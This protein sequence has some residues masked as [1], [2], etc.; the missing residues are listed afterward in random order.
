MTR[1]A[2]NFAITCWCRNYST[3][4]HVS[5]ECE[6]HRDLRFSVAPEASRK[7]RLGPDRIIGLTGGSPLGRKVCIPV[8]RVL[9]GC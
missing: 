7:R 4:L 9:A 8:K 1:R 6:A 5:D 3:S 2:K